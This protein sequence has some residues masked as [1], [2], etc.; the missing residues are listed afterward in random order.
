MKHFFL[1]ALLL[2]YLS[3]SGIVLH[4]QDSLSKEKKPARALKNTIRFNVSNPLIFGSGSVIFGY[5]RTIGQHQSISIDIGNVYFREPHILPFD[6]NG[7]YI[8]VNKSMKD[9]GFH[10]AIDYRFYLRKENKYPSP[11][12][13]YLAPFYSYN[14]FSRENTWTLQTKNFNGDLT[15]TYKLQLNTVGCEL[16]YQ[17]ILWKR[18]ALDLI[19][20]GPGITFYNISS[21]INTSLNPDDES[22]LF[23]KLN[24]VI[25]ERI[26]GYNLAIDGSE[27][28][29]KGSINTLSLGFRYMVHLGFRF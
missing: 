4:A 23:K 25:S 21:T 15:T 24:E 17:F 20:M 19:L 5:E 12:G 29:K 27:F 8:Q 28:E 6:Y 10:T 2:L 9:F 13:V 1:R 14:F 16:G 26:P 18:L 3:M 22:E 7:T 11:R